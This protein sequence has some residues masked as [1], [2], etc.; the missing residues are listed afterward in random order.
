MYYL[1]KN[2]N[3]NE[4]H[5]KDICA[6]YQEAI[7]ETLVEKTVNAALSSGV[8]SVVIAGG[9]AC[10]S[11]LRELGKKRFEE[12]G[13][14][15]FIPSPKYCTDNAAMI[16]ALGLFKLNEGEYS[17]LSLNPYSTSRPK[18][19]RGRGLIAN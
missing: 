13:I 15:L 2:P 5:L 12:E 9:V 14:S 6:S 1:K 19:I 7:V 16:G 11:R 17:E 3:L 8:K 10:N 18:Y 4:E